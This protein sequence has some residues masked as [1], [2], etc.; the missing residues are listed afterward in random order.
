MAERLALTGADFELHYCTRNRER[1]A[2][3][4]RIGRSAFVSNVRFHFDDGAACQKLDLSS[5][6]PATQQDMHIYVC[7]PKGFIDAVL[8]AA[9][10]RGWL[11]SNLHFESFTALEVDTGGDRPFQVKLASS[12]RVVDVPPG[13]SVEQ[14]LAEIGVDVPTSCQEG[15]C[16]TCLTRILEGTPDH[17]D[18]FLMPAE[19][20]RND[21]FTPCCS[22]SKSSILVLDL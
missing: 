20:A 9:R 3:A 18:V 4:D 14:A 12:G 1:T 15:L 22:R 8:G 6:I 10:D 17:R 13:K 21:Q 11:E 16:G 2:F 7:G 19:Q 5:V